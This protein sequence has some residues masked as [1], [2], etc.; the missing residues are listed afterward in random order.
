MV[1]GI[2]QLVSRAVPGQHVRWIIV[3]PQQH[4]SFELFEQ[5]GAAVHL[6]LCKPSMPLCV[7]GRLCFGQFLQGKPCVNCRGEGLFEPYLTY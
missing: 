1:F 3:V 6:A 5:T 2:V 7:R 4:T